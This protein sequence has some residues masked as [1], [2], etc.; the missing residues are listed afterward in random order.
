MQS[1]PTA[2][3]KDPIRRSHRTSSGCD[4]KWANRFCACYVALTL[5]LG[6]CTPSPKDGNLSGCFLRPR[7]DNHE[8]IRVF[9]PGSPYQASTDRFGRFYIPN[10][11]PGDYEIVVQEDGYSEIRKPVRIAAGALVNLPTQTLLSLLPSTGSV[12]GKI[13][14]EGQ[15]NHQGTLVLLVGT[16]H[17]QITDQTGYFRFTEVEL[18]TYQLVALKDGFQSLSDVQVNLEKPIELSLPDMPLIPIAAS[19]ESPTAKPPAGD[20]RL[21]GAALL[22]GEIN[23][24]G[25][26]VSVLEDSALTAIT[27]ADGSFRVE[28]L[29]DGP[30]TLK[31]E[32]TGFT[33]QQLSGITPFSATE[34]IGIHITLRPERNPGGRGVLQ[35]FVELQDQTNHEGTTVRLIGIPQSVLTDNTGRYIFVDI[36]SISYILEASHPGY[37]TS[38]ALGVEVVA[39][40]INEAPLLELPPITVDDLDG[41]IEGYGAIEG[42]VTLEDD[43]NA[44]G[45]TIGVQTANLVALSAPG[46]AFSFNDVPAGRHLVIFEKAGYQTEYLEDVPVIPNQVTPL[47]PM[48]LQREIE[49]PYVVSTDPRNRARRVGFDEFVDVTVKFSDRM[50]GDSVKRSVFISPP[51][52]NRMFF[53]RE[54]ELSDSDTLHMQLLRAGRQ[55][56]R[57]KTNYEIVIGQ[58]ASNVQGIPLSD[59]YAFSFTTDGPLI[60]R[61]VPADGEHNVT[62]FPA[63]RLLIETNAPID[64]A[65]LADALRIHPRPQSVPEPF[66]SRRGSGGRVEIEV[67]LNSAT[68]YSISIGKQL[69]T[70]DGELFSNTPYRFTFNIAEVRDNVTEP[71]LD[72]RGRRAR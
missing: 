40:T 6:G 53:G 69:R 11:T 14:L 63:D 57:F 35:G 55:G 58:S 28:N 13:L 64:P 9:S 59:D 2:P 66:T 72:V 23:H 49:H 3:Q 70:V 32:H 27:S 18:G 60:V 68:K 8:G 67:G 10:I 56:L 46:G 21:W 5:L 1:D 61:T 41:E 62:F 54:S 48:V 44:G 52:A 26:Y 12:R 24:S 22:E 37:K 17:N 47:K 30:Y 25:T 15:E 45:V 20:L 4:K 31:F 34:G 16:A 19:V 38:R 36:P 50:D 42:I 7:T 65:T 51:V 43:P 71:D 29:G 39:N 33:A